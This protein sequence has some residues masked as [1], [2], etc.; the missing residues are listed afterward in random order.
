[1]KKDL[2]D[3]CITTEL[4]LEPF[5]SFL[6]L[7][8]CL[9]FFSAPPF[10]VFLSSFFPDPFRFFDLA[11]YCLFSFFDLVFYRPLFS[12]FFFALVLSLFL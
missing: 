4:P 7:P 2:N 10:I 8:F 5:R 3:W 9:S 11:L 6:L 12:L 1:V